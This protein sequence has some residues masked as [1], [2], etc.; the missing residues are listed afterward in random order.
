MFMFVSKNKRKK[1]KEKQEKKFS[2]SLT[3]L[4]FFNNNVEQNSSFTFF[5]SNNY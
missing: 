1:I 3:A 5:R 4:I 2:I